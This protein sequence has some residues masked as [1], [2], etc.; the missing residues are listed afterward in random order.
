MCFV[1][2]DVVVLFAFKQI[3]MRWKY[4][5]TQQIKER[6][7]QVS[8]SRWI[9]EILCEHARYGIHPIMKPETS[10]L[11]F[12][13]YLVL[14]ICVFIKVSDL[15]QNKLSSSLWNISGRTS[16]EYG[17]QHQEFQ[18][19]NSTHQHILTILLLTSASSQ[20]NLWLLLV[21]RLKYGG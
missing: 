6:V 14:Q 4:F 16:S 9:W 19:C 5:W 21:H 11:W 10:R 8:D 1:V 18:T 12:S 20:H 17:M 7:W 13:F 2:Q 15:I 3:V